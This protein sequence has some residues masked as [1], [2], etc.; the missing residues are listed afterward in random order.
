MTL[1][2]FWP[3]AR[4]QEGKMRDSGGKYKT[5]RWRIEETFFPTKQDVFQASFD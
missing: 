2:V 3:R 4:D 5:K 1:T